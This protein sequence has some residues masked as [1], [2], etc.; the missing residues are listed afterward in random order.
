MLAVQPDVKADGA[1]M[2]KS[3][4]TPV[5]AEVTLTVSVGVVTVASSPWTA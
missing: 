2:A 5:F 4:S 3:A 1:E